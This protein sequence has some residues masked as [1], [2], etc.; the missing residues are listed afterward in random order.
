MNLAM[1]VWYWSGLF[2]TGALCFIGFLVMII[3]LMIEESAT[4]EQRRKYARAALVYLILGPLWTVL[5]PLT[6]TWLSVKG[7]I[8]LVRIAR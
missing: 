6:L 8:R 5:W 7:L 2:I 4:P 1:P 3:S